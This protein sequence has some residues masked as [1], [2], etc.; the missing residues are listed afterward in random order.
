MPACLSLLSLILLAGACSAQALVLP[1]EAARA[2]GNAISTHWGF[3]QTRF[4]QT[5]GAKHFRAPRLIREIAFRRDG[6]ALP[7]RT[8][9]YSWWHNENAHAV[10]LALGSADPSMQPL[11]RFPDP[12]RWT[13]VFRR[14]RIVLPDLPWGNARTQPFLVRFKLDAPYLHVQG[15]LMLD[16]QIGHRR[17]NDWTAYAL[18]AVRRPYGEISVEHWGGGSMRLFA[19]VGEKLQ[20]H[21]FGAQAN[22][23]VVVL[24]GVK[25]RPAPIHVEPLALLPRLAST[26]GSVRIELPFRPHTEMLVQYLQ[27][28]P[29][30]WS[31]GIRLRTKRGPIDEW[32]LQANGILKN[33]PHGFVE[34]NTMLVTEFR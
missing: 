22:T 4:V 7:G 16:V 15:P 19:T 13:K 1:P 10:D 20:L 27:P 30:R 17:W 24:L 26:S 5:Y 25:A 18:D 31:P 8:I 11:S 14:D 32:I 9:S 21:C 28:W 34:R 6:L 3:N 2:E 33:G 12:E 23:P 29:P